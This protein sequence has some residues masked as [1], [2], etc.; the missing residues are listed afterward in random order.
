MD[1]IVATIL[2]IILAI[3]ALFG[4]KELASKVVFYFSKKEKNSY[5]AGSSGETIGR[6]KV[7]INISSAIGNPEDLFRNSA[8]ASEENNEALFIKRGLD[9]LGLSQESVT[10]LG[11]IFAIVFKE[12]KSSRNGL[13]M[14]NGALYS[15][16]SKGS[17][18]EWREHC[19]GSLRELIH[20]CRG[21]GQ[22]ANWFCQAFKAKNSAFPNSTTHSTE[23]ARIDGFY[24]YF[25]EI[26][27]HNSLH[28]IQRLQ[29]LYGERIK[30][31]DDTPE[32]FIIAVKDFIQM[33]HTFFSTHVKQL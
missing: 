21:E 6:D 3:L 16:G 13:S 32:R 29:F 14:L 19:A 23:Y 26:H 30:V 1:E 8:I 7:T 12:N 20:E 24:N 2:K 15:L 31:G 28:I 33:L 17:N 27:H 11:N 10:Y 18:P 4:G 5:V 9:L 22:I 25:S